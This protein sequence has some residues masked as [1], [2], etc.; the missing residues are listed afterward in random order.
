[1]CI[2]V[3]QPI[4]VLVHLS[5]L[6]FKNKGLEALL[7]HPNIIKVRGGHSLTQLCIRLHSLL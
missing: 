3:L 7:E 1:M 4:C 2:R 5:S 6:G